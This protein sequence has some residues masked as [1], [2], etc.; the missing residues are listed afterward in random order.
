VSKSSHPLPLTRLCA[1]C[2]ADV[3]ARAGWSLVD[4]AA[5]CL[6]GGARMLQVRA[7]TLSGYAFLEAVRAIVDRARPSSALVIVNDRADIA[8]LAG[9]GG[10][11]VGQD[12]LTPAQVRRVGGD[13]MIVGLSTHTVA[14]VDAAIDQRI[15]Y[16]AI[17]PVYSTA[18]KVTG[19]D[20]VGLVAVRAAC[21]RTSASG[22]PVMAIGG[23]TLERASLVVQAGAS[24]VA[25]I[26]DLLAGG[27]P[28]TRVR[29]YLERL[30]G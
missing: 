1:I 23:I 6:E 25:V 10:V 9:A 17:G 13:D 7:K 27:D 15:D 11:H 4:F 22:L 5:A 29:A 12:D 21:A 16:L 2:D 20:A 3:C 8:R 26:G 28:R 19:Y 14:Q 18:T 30:G 24:A